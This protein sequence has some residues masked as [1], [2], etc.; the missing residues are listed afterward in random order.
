MTPKWKR[1]VIRRAL[2]ALLWPW[3]HLGPKR[4]RIEPHP[5]WASALLYHHVVRW[6]REDRWA[7]MQAAVLAAN[8][9]IVNALTPSLRACTRAT[10]SFALACASTEESAMLA[11]TSGSER[12]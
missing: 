2:E 7:A 9:A 6:E 10:Q 11:P 4:Q 3:S 8:M 1:A 12:E 5:Q